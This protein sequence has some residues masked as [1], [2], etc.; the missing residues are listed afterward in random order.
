VLLVPAKAQLDLEFATVSQ[1]PP[2]EQPD[3]LVIYISV[4]SVLAVMDKLTV[5]AVVEA[6]PELMSNST[7]GAMGIVVV[8]GELIGNVVVVELIVLS[9]F[10]FCSNSVMPPFI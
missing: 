6:A 10:K 3:V 4:A 5:N 1:T 2:A 9:V 8:V 7:V